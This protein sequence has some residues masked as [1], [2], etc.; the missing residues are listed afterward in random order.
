[1]FG[2]KCCKNKLCFSVK[3]GACH[4]GS[5]VDVFTL[6]LSLGR[7]D[8]ECVCVSVCVSVCERACVPAC[9]QPQALAGQG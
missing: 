3:K 6:V 5:P 7:I 1:M 9:D 2:A 8:P 4:S